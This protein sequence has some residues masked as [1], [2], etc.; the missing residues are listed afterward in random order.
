[1]R[2]DENRVRR[3][4]VDF[5]Q[6]TSP[7]FAHDHQAIAHFCEAAQDPPLLRSRF[8][9]QCVQ[10][11]DLR[12]AEFAEQLYE[13]LPFCSPVNTEFVLDAY[14]IV[15]VHVQ[16]FGRLPVVRQALLGDFKLDLRRIVVAVGHVIGRN[17]N[18]AR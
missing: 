7:H 1:M 8:A 16:V 11:R 10:R 3:Y 17:R 13:V 5:L 4:T 14:S 18:H 2:D 12:H 15:L 9:Q 6:E